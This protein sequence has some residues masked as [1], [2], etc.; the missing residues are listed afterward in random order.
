MYLC[1]SVVLDIIVFNVLNL[2]TLMKKNCLARHFQ[3]SWTVYY[4]ATR[5]SRW[6]RL[7]YGRKTNKDK[8]FMMWMLELLMVVDKLGLVMNIWKNFVFTWIFLSLCFQIIINISLQ[9]EEAV[10]R[11]AEE[12]CQLPRPNYVEQQRV[13]MWVFLLTEHGSVKALHPW[14]EL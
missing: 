13:P 8:N 9:L 4:I 1:Y 11:V 2:M 10:K 7:I 3:L 14:M 6:D 5:F 12:V